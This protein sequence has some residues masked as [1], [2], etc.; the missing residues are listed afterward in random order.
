MASANKHCMELQISLLN[1][2]PYQQAI[3]LPHHLVMSP[4]RDITTNANWKGA[5]QYEIPVLARVNEDDSETVLPRLS[6]RLSIELVQKKLS[7]A[8]S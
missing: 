7:A 4:V 1:E 2:L 8:L 5:Y 6:P 3:R